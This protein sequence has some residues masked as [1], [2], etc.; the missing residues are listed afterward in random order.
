MPSLFD[1]LE[2]ATLSLPNR[3]VMSPM[4]RSRHFTEGVPSP[5]APTYYSQRASAGLIIAEST[6]PNVVGQ[7]YLATPGM[8]TDAQASGWRAVTEAVKQAG[9]RIFLQLMH[10]GRIGHPDLLP[11]GHHPVGPSPV[12]AAG[13]SFT[14]EGPKDLTVPKEL[15]VAEIADTVRDFASAADR[16]IGAGFDGV[17]IHAAYG[18]LLQQFM[19]SNANQ[20]V[21]S[22]GGNVPNRIR[23]AVEVVT[24]VADRIG[25]HRVGI[26][27]S[28]GTPEGPLN[29]IVEDD[30]EDVYRSLIA[31]FEP[32]EIGY[33]H[34]VETDSAFLNAMV[35][36]SW[37]GVLIVNPKGKDGQ[38][39]VRADGERVLAA[40]ADAASFGRA[41]LANPDLPARFQR[42]AALNVAAPEVFYGGD[43][44]GY[45]DW[46]VL[47]DSTT[48][49]VRPATSG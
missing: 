40:G 30:A 37:R 5:L 18:Y 34:Y 31:A 25:A 26:R 3:I 29:D 49:S 46:P 47:A 2:V 43:H 12:R 32:I 7:G 45:I 23:L 42:D 20:R 8:H 13:L 39:A 28:P 27:V 16:A 1:P 41:F 22:Y 15:T 33:L 19:S 35:R 36:E 11:D 48:D 10:A 14:A 4:T 6:Q 24:A 44:R 17:E 38:A 21:D 9:G